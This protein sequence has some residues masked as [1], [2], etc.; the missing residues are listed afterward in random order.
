MALL[1]A[2]GLAGASGAQEAAPGSPPPS[3]VAGAWLDRYCLDCHDRESR[4]GALDLESIRSDDVGQRADVWERV[5]RKLA[6]RQMPPPG[7]RRPDEEAYT[8]IVARLEEA[9]DQAA[10]GRPRPGRTDALRRLNRIE[11]QNAIRDLL[12]LDIDAAALLPGDESSHGFDNVT[13]GELSPTLLERYLSAAQR[14]SRLAVGGTR[15]SPDVEIIRIRPDLTQEERIEGLPVGTRGGALIPCFFPASGE[16]EVQVRLARDR[17]EEVEGLGEPH[18]LEILLDRKRVGL[19]TVAPPPD[20]KSYE[21]VDRHLKVRLPVSAGPH[22][23]GVT[24]LKGPSALLETRRQPYSAHFNRHRHP[25]ISPAVYQVTIAGPQSTGG[26]AESPGE[27]PSRRRIFIA[28]P[29][30]PEDEEECA[31]RILS[32][33]MRRAYRRPIVVEDLQRPLELYRDTRRGEGFDAGI[34][35]ALSAILVSPHFLFRIEEDPAGGE[36]GAPHRISDLELASRLSFFLW[37][38]IPDDE[39]LEAAIRGALSEPAELERQAR[40]LLADPRSRS[41]VTSFAAQWLHLRNLDSIT[42]DLRLFA[43]FDDNL[44]QAFRRETELFLESVLRED[45]SVLDLLRASYTFLDERLARHYEVPYVYGSRFRRVEMGEEGPEASIGPGRTRGGLLRQ[46]S[47]LTVTSYA[48]RTSPVIR[49]RWILENLLGAPPPP[50]PP[51][52]PALKETVVSGSLSVRDRLAEHRADPACA[53]C[54]RL[55]DPVGF[56]LEGFDAVGRW[57]TLEAGKP[58]D[59]SGGLPDGSEV[60]GVSGLEEALLR[61]PELFVGTLSEKLL[62]FALGRGV[63][64][65]DA[66]AIREVVRRARAEGYRFSSLVLGVV[67]SA[68][69]QMRTSR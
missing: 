17:N 3:P 6:R 32:A 24:F 55:M 56:P 8:E 50:P 54:H 39:L 41:L 19:L 68:P 20:G 35:M 59:D 46:G 10:A 36:P 61:R 45:R 23:L 5:V 64:G 7:K 16:Y 1:A 33:L 2:L 48:T 30:G 67:K 49:G 31:R 57:R 47:I 51:N 58:I 25:R 29:T 62:T 14:I 21:A 4:N 37:S 52:V 65:H 22:D 9:L 42:P 12:A 43:D 18:E 44:R 15:R 26:P 13:V 69:F 11:Y 28:R 27:T 63:E 66:P 40:R 60:S 53:G 38:S 34:E